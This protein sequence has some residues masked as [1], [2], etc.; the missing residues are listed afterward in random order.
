MVHNITLRRWDETFHFASV[1]GENW[2]PLNRPLAEGEEDDFQATLD[3]DGN[4]LPMKFARRWFSFQRPSESAMTINCACERC[5]H[6]ADWWVS[7]QISA[8]L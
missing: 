2:L 3:G 4:F 5:R 7:Q 8:A 1:D 6:L